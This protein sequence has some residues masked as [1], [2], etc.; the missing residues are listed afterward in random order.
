MEEAAKPP[1]DVGAETLKKKKREGVKSRPARE[2]AAPLCVDV[3]SW[4]ERDADV[5]LL[6]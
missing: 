5:R 1:A 4:S 3:R 6:F 2:Q